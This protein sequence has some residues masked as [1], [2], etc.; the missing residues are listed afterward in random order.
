MNQLAFQQT[1]AVVTGASSGIGRAIATSLARKG[2]ERMVIHYCKNADGAQATAKA[3]AEHGAATVVIPCNLTSSESIQAFASACFVELGEVHTWVNN[4][5][6]DVLTGAGASLSFDE[7]LKRLMQVDVLGTIELSRLVAERLMKQPSAR[8]SSMT[9]IGWDQA[10]EGM[11]G[12][13]GQMFGPVKTA[14]TAYAKSLAQSVAPKL[15]VNTIAPGW[16]RTSWGES[17]D[18]YWNRRA[19]EQSLMYRWGT[20]DDVALAVLFASDPA[21]TFFTGQLVRVNGGWNRRSPRSEKE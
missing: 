8:P 18:P 3:C 16:I 9:F 12:D 7:K 14:V 13:A 17:T 19:K 10:S 15:R 1:H 5:G 6:A 11:E 20:P 21:N 4:A 2:V